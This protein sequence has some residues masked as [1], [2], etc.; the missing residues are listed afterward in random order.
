MKMLGSLQRVKLI[1][2][3]HKFWCI[4]L[5]LVFILSLCG[6][7]AY[8]YKYRQIKKTGLDIN[9]FDAFDFARNAAGDGDPA[10]LKNLETTDGTTNILLVGIDGRNGDTSFNTDTIMLLSYNHEKKETAQISFPRDLQ[11]KYQIG[12]RYYDTKINGVFP[13]TIKASANTE[14]GIQAAF[15]NLGSALKNYTGL[16]VHYGVMINFQGFKDIV[17]S[18]GNITVIVEN[19]FT[20]TEYPN[21]TDTGSITVHFDAGRV[22]MDGA[23]ALRY[24]RSRKGDNNEASD[25]ARARRQQKV[26]NA[27]KEKMV[28][29]NLFSQADS[30]NKLITA[31]GNNVTFYNIGSDEINNVIKARSV[32]GNIALYST[33]ID[34]AFGSYPNQLLYDGGLEKSYVIF[35]TDDNIPAVKKAVQSF[36]QNSFWSIENP[37]VRIV[38]TDA[39]RANDYI[40]AKQ[41]FWNSYLKFER[42]DNLVQI[43]ASP[44][45]TSTASNGFATLYVLNQTKTKSAEYLVKLFADNQ[46]TLLVQDASQLPEKLTE[47]AQSMD[48]LLVID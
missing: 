19:S 14:Q 46:K 12:N 18:V 11:A 28:Q 37:K 29:A 45:P 3:H 43:K 24:A 44:T 30:V 4:I 39:M 9:V 35:P 41:V 22:E 36:L 15:K 21:D 13:N 1:I 32:F 7:S 8:Y 34:P 25:F 47:S 26:I 27:I 2:L 42:E 38:R 6:G 10:A 40:K 31:L 48:F 33:V 17:D 20:D 23:T 5:F 16:D